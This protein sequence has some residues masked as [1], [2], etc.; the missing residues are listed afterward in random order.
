MTSVVTG[1]HDDTCVTITYGGTTL[2][3]SATI[4]RGETL[5]Y[6]SKDTPT[7]VTGAYI[8]ATKVVSVLTGNG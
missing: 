1:I 2:V 8:N 6:L 5:Q 3:S 4:N 7:D